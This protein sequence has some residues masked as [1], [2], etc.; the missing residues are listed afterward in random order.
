MIRN[1]KALRLVQMLLCSIEKTLSMKIDKL[2]NVVD[3]GFTVDA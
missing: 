1:F 3:T 2:E